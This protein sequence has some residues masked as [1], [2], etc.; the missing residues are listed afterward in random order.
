GINNLVQFGSRIATVPAPV[1][2][3]LR[4]C[5]EA[6]EPMAVEDRLYEGA[7]VTV[8]E[9]PFMGAY[10]IVVRVLP[11]RRRVQILLDFLG[12]ATL[13]EVERK[14]VTVENKCMA[15]LMPALASMPRVAIAA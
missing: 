1:I 3:E 15:D 11:A 10:G 12:R 4:V 7:E 8:A 5:F 2:D 13:A 6:G 9:G 14:S